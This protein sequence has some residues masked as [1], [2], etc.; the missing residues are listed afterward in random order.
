MLSLE[1]YYRYNDDM[2]CECGSQVVAVLKSGSCKIGL[3]EECLDELTK[4][5]TE[6]NETVFCHKCKYG[7]PNRFGW[8]YGVCCTKDV[9]RAGK[10]IEEVNVDYDYLKDSM[11]TCDCGE[12]GK[13]EG[14]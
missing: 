7:I 14:V 4:S 6:F 3:C 12:K 5:L 9:E 10:K 1:A 8:N 11:D 13:Y 2:N